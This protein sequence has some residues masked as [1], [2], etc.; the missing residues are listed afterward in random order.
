MIRKFKNKILGYRYS[1][2]PINSSKP[3]NYFES[4]TP[5][6][7]AQFKKNARLHKATFL[8]LGGITS[9]SY[10]MSSFSDKDRTIEQ[11]M[12]DYMVP[13]LKK[14]QPAQ[15]ETIK[16]AKELVD[17]IFSREDMAEAL[18][19]MT[20]DVTSERQMM[21]TLVRML[22]NTLQE[23][24]LQN[25]G[26][27]FIETVLEMLLTDDKS[28]RDAKKLLVRIVR[29]K[30]NQKV[31][32]KVLIEVTKS[33]R[34][35]QSTSKLFNKATANEDVQKNLDWLRDCV[36]N[37]I[38]LNQES[39]TKIVDFAKE[40]LD[41]DGEMLQGRYMLGQLMMR[42][43]KKEDGVSDIQKLLESDEMD[44]DNL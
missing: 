42:V 36:L 25:E 32:Q 33:D 18:I 35:V 15:K 29:D 43:F 26:V 20:R 3:K 10:F 22:D 17:G 14:D 28:Y 4:I 2:T 21:E 30:E 16:L 31:I 1:T 27:K 11:K 24:K 9:F 39:T 40:V 44:A 37:E 38:L 12:I 41:V 6:E 13:Y 7:Y 5:S 19:L 8:F 34:L 23:P